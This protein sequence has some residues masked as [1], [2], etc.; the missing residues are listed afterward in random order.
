MSPATRNPDA[1]DSEYVSRILDIWQDWGD[2]QAFLVTVAAILGYQRAGAA[3]AGVAKPTHRDVVRL[4]S[5]HYRDAYA[6]R[7]AEERTS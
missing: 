3:L 7:M 1:A 6:I 5:E 4:F 2:S